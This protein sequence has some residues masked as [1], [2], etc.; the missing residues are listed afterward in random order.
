MWCMWYDTNIQSGCMKC[1][2]IWMLERGAKS[3]LKG[4]GEGGGKVH[5]F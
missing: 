5:G 1:G 3:G 4:D 2:I